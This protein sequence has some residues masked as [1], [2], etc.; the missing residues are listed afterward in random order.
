MDEL[1]KILS[2]ENGVSGNETAVRSIIAKKIKEQADDIMTD[3]MGNLIVLKKGKN[4]SKMIAVTAHM[5]EVGFIISG[6][7][8]TGYLKFKSVGTIDSRKIIS[9][10]VVIGDNKVK[11]I[12]GMKAIHLQTKSEREN[13]VSVSKLFIDI[14]AK[15]KKDAEK[16]VRLGDYVTFDTDF[17]V[18]G[19]NVKGKALDRS[20]V[21]SALINAMNN[22]YPFDT[23]FC[24]LTQHEVGSRG[25]KIISHRLNP[26]AVLTV[27]T[28]DTE[29]MYGCEKNSGGA[30]LGKGI[31][32]SYSDKLFIAD[33]ELT[34]KLAETAYHENILVQT[35]AA[36]NFAS[37]TGA[38]QTGAEGTRCISVSIPCRYSHSP[39]SIMSLKD[40]EIA[41]KYIELFLN[42]IGELV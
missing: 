16:S 22:E 35:N 20:G 26:D 5:D 42:K 18:I 9:K 13:T 19:S 27:S 7:T 36:K 3:S 30:E 10:K 32:V 11:G 38:I 4:S 15:N 25:A 40:V 24:F 29:D 14:G 23:Y 6:I 21:C 28:V 31:V 12:I 41:S 34:D 39:V 37:D 1:L 2:E 17:E 33:K 8:D